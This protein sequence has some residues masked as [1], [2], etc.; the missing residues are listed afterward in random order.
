MH[1]KFIN[2]LWYCSFD[3]PGSR[4]NL[5]KKK[6]KCYH[7]E[8]SI[9]LLFFSAKF[10]TNNNQQ[11]RKKTTNQINLK[12]I[13]RKAFSFCELINYSWLV[14]TF[15]LFIITIIIVI[16]KITNKSDHRRE[17]KR[18]SINAINFRFTYPKN[19]KYYYLCLYWCKLTV[20]KNK[21]L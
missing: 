3:W 8:A 11:K 13:K 6:Q 12:F 7:M 4:Q 15:A 2:Y 9:V 16:G 18:D 5:E 14:I 20:I 21:L 17:K 10:Q 1:W 19:S